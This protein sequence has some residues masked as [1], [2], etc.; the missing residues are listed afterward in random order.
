M[1]PTTRSP[2]RA[3]RRDFLKTAGLA[4]AAFAA[5]ACARLTGPLGGLERGKPPNMLF[6]FGDDHACR[7][8]SAYG[9]K[10]NKTPNI[11]R[12]AKEGAIFLNNFCTNSIYAP[13][14][15]VVFS[16]K[17][18]HVNGVITNAS[19]FDPSQPAPLRRA[20]RPA[21]AD[22]LLRLRRVGAFRSR[23]GSP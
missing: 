8:I 1:T 23:A 16:G 13:S 21:Q 14:R 2:N 17:H 4:A 6:I 20:D 10:I 18:S 22:L 5:P 3:T 9:L 7:A 15:A 11:D 12:V 19:E